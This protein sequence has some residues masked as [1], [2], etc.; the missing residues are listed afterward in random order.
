VTDESGLI[1]FSMRVI[2]IDAPAI[3]AADRAT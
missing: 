3:C 2:G 1:L